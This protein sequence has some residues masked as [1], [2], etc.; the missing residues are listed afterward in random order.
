MSLVDAMVAM[1]FVSAG[2][3]ALSAGAV[4][5]TRGSKAADETSVATALAQQK[6]EQLRSMPLG[7]VGLLPGTYADPV[8]PLRADGNAGTGARFTRTW[9]VSANDQ[10]RWGM[11]TVTVSVSWRDTRPHVARLAAYVRCSRVPC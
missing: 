9:V 3:L 7:A 10:P 8:N 11:R 1:L 4:T 2:V 5:L 6:L